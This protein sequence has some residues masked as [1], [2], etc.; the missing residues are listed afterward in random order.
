MAS[1]S[2]SNSLFDIKLPTVLDGLSSKTTSKTTSTSDNVN[3]VTNNISINLDDTNTNKLVESNNN[4]V[5]SIKDFIEKTIHKSDFKTTGNTDDEITRQIRYS[6]SNSQYLNSKL[7][8]KLNIGRDYSKYEIDEKS[9]WQSLQSTSNNSGPGLASSLIGLIGEIGKLADKTVDEETGKR[10]EWSKRKTTYDYLASKLIPDKVN[11]YSDSYTKPSTLPIPSILGSIDSF[12]NSSDELLL[13]YIKESYSTKSS[14]DPADLSDSI[15]DS[16]DKMRVPNANS[17]YHTDSYANTKSMMEKEDAL[18]REK[19]RDLAAQRSVDYLAKSTGLLGEIL[20]EIKDIKELLKPEEEE[21]DNP[22]MDMFDGDGGFDLWGRDKS[23]NRSGS[24]KSNSKSKNKSKSNSKSKPRARTRSGSNSNSKS[25]FSNASSRTSSASVKPT[26]SASAT[27]KIAKGV[28]SVAT[29]AGVVGTVLTVGEGVYDYATAEDTT[30]REQAVSTTTGA[31]GGTVAGAKVGAVAGAAIGSVVPVVGTAVGGVVGGVAG[32]TAGYMAGTKLGG[33]FQDKFLW[34]PEDDIPDDIREKQDPRLEMEYLD[35]VLLK[36]YIENNDEEKLKKAIEYRNKLA[37]MAEVLDPILDEMQIEEMNKPISSNTESQ[38]FFSKY[39][40]KIMG[41]D[42]TSQSSKPPKVK[43]SLTDGKAPPPDLGTSTGEVIL[44]T[45][46]MDDGKKVG[47][48]GEYF[49]TEGKNK[50]RDLS[51]IHPTFKNALVSAFKEYY[52][53][54]GNIPR[55]SETFRSTTEQKVFWDKYQKYGKP[56][57]ARPGTSK[58]ER[59]MAV[60]IYS[61]ESNEMANMGIYAKYGL[62][63]PIGSEPW[64][65]EMP[66]LK[67]ATPPKPMPIEDNSDTQ[68]AKSVTDVSTDKLASADT[69]YDVPKSQSVLPSAY[70]ERESE[71]LDTDVRAL[72][73]MDDLSTATPKSEKS[74][75]K[76]MEMAATTSPK[77]V[78]SQTV[79]ASQTTQPMGVIGSGPPPSAPAPNMSNPF[80]IDN[81]NTELL[82]HGL[83]LG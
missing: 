56:L 76:D 71:Y 63:R 62:A 77:P 40:N 24:K 11:S 68:T 74:I 65:V 48:T 13:P 7:K 81:Q 21:A 44:N 5:S 79:V 23:G 15:L 51:K 16:L 75:V 8:N 67:N 45:E 55:L 60:D 52:L 22:F 80:T 25:K 2:K 35:E 36:R 39:Y 57:A 46:M 53:K 59:G 37:V 70:T 12:D 64:H 20:E 31:L 27:S 38:S 54:T 33:W 19:D 14:I 29:K 34:D 42:T 6:E 26:T 66:G 28:G 78:Q 49:K 30:G 47:D 1:N 50:G 32:A 4:L 82:R 43:D 58:H 61:A 9:V 72:N 73:E 10:V 83:I 69:K 41:N 18:Q 17:M 3:N